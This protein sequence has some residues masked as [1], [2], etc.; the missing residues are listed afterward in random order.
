MAPVSNNCPCEGQT[1]T[2]ERSNL[3]DAENIDFL[4]DSSSMLLKLNAN[5]D[6]V[7]KMQSRS[8]DIEAQRL[9]SSSFSAVE[10]SVNEGW[11]TP[12]T[13]AYRIPE[14]HDCPPAPR[15]RR[16]VGRKRLAGKA[17]FFKPQDF[18]LF[19]PRDKLRV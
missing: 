17:S 2:P 11:Q 12:K 15:K 16:A 6:P 1:S 18:D 9:D 19:F 5:Q 4:Y 8:Q 7:V 13:K 14:L 10:S 3:V